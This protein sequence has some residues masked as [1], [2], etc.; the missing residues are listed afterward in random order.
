MRGRFRFW[1]WTIQV[2]SRCRPGVV[3]TGN[4]SH[5]GRARSVFLSVPRFQGCDR[6]TV[7]HA[8]ADS[9]RVWNRWSTDKDPRGEAF[10]RGLTA[11]T[12]NLCSMT[13]EVYLTIQRMPRRY[14]Y[15][16]H[17]GLGRSARSTKPAMQT[18]PTL[19]SHHKH[20][21]HDA[22]SAPTSKAVM[23][24]DVHGNSSKPPNKI[25][26]R[27]ESLSANHTLHHHH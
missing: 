9:H 18:A 6:H 23:Q 5:Y 7:P 26:K 3:G 27:N 10:H 4:K 1:P 2:R 8:E 14:K 21:F 17:P 24:I 15:F 22:R 19:A 11:P 12:H 13:D 25:K 20:A 16:F